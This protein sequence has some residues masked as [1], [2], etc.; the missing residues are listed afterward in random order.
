[1]VHCFE[2][3]G[4]Y[5]AADIDSGS[6]FSVDRTAYDAICL[7]NE[8][9]M[10]EARKKFGG[11]PAVF[12]EIQ[13]LIDEGSLFSAYDYS[14]VKQPQSVIKALCLHIAHDCDLRCRYCFASTGTFHGER[15]LMSAETGKRAL[16]FLFA[17]SGSRKNVEV[18]FFGGEP[19]LNLDA[20][21]ETVN[22]GRQLEKETGKT[23]HFTLTTNCMKLTKETADYLNE[24]MFN[25]VLSL[26]GR[27]EVHDAMRPDA[28]GK[29]SF[30]TALAN[31][32]YMAEIRG[33]KSYYVRGTFTAHNLDF[34]EDVFALYNA[35]FGQISIEPV[36][37]DEKHPYAIRKEHLPAILAEYEKLAA[38]Y[39]Q[40]RKQ[41]QGFNFFHFMMDTENGPCISK[42]LGGC[43]AGNEYAAVTPNGDI[44]PCHQFVGQK[45]FCMGSLYG[46]NA[47]EINESVR[48]R[49]AGN[50]VLAKPDCMACWAK[51][52]CSG[53]CAANSFHQN[54]DVAKPYALSCEM[55]KKRIE[56]ALAIRAAEKEQSALES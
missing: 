10:A 1:M 48:S 47:M 40:C 38:R 31:A 32:R 17:K 45:E 9:G 15:S 29:G 13:A 21:K 43:G 46:E 12:E 7:A 33:E 55:Q 23:V 6:V 51:Y 28:G 8:Y 4:K 41:E 24:E 16:D 5:M 42:R 35:G 30:D 56:C 26:D 39:V 20:V 49:F 37:T 25:I 44:Y 53:G 27:K 52:Y 22:H 11:D 54:G 3:L 50:T 2:A 34:A 19:L 36:V 18:D 14:A